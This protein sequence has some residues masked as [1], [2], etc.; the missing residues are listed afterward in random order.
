M[1]ISVPAI[2]DQTM[3]SFQSAALRRSGVK[4]SQCSTAPAPPHK[5]PDAVVFNT[6]S[7]PFSVTYNTVPAASSTAMRCSGMRPRTP[8]DH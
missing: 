5:R 1:H 7:P 2:D 6:T 8:N 3:T 4:Y